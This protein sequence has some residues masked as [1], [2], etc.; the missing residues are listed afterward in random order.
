MRGRPNKTAR[1]PLQN[2]LR[3]RRLELGLTLEDV[4]ERA[5]MSLISVQRKE[6]GERQL[7]V[8]ELEALAKALECE[9]EDLLPDS[10]RLVP[11]V[12]RVGA[13]ARVFPIDDFPKGGGLYRVACPRGLN[14]AQTVAVEV[15][16]ESMYPEV[17]EGWVLFYSREHESPA[18][19]VLGRLCVVKVAHDG[20][21][22]VKRV[23]RGPTPGKF[24]LVSAN[25]P[26]MEDVELE[27]ATPVRAHVDPELAKAA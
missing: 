23:A 7:K 16:G 18:Q 5:H 17:P 15:I 14:P 1:V 27:W 25:A 10:V 24:N 12:G 22:L 26:V 21:T 19:A 20:P 8:R 13:G 2:R 6:T 3:A 4:A 11:V 9:P